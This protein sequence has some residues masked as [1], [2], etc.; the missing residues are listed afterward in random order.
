MFRPEQQIGQYILIRRLGRGGFGE[1]WLAE[2]R[3]KFVTTKVAVKLPLDEQVDH[4]AIRQ[5]AV[6]WEQASGHPNVLPIIEADDYD[7]QVVIVSEYAPDGSLEDLLKKNNGSLPL[8]QAVEMTIG[9]LAGLDFL[10]SRNIIH[11]DLKPANI[12]LQGD[13]PRLADFG[14]SRAMKTTSVSVNIAGTPIYMS[15]E[16]FDRKRNVQTDI[17]AIGVM[18]YQMLTGDFPFPIGNIS[19]IIASIVMHEAEPLPDE[20]PPKLQ[21]IVKK[22]LAKQPAERYQTARDMRGDLADFF[23]SIS[24]QE[25]QETLKFKKKTE[26][27]EVK[28]E[29]LPSDSIAQTQASSTMQSPVF[30]ANT[31]GQKLAETI[32]SNE[33]LE[34]PKFESRNP[35]TNSLYLKILAPFSVLVLLIAGVWLYLSINRQTTTADVIS[36]STKDAPLIPIKTEN[37]KIRYVFV[38]ISDLAKNIIPSDNELKDYYDS[39]PNSEKQAGVLGQEIVLRIASSNSEQQVLEKANQIVVQLKK[40]DNLVS[41]QVFSESAKG[42][43]ENPT[44]ASKGGELPG[45]VRPNPSNPDDPYQRL[46]TMQ[47]GEITEPIKYQDRYFILRRGESVPKTFEEARKEIKIS[48]I[49]QHAYQAAEDIAQKI[50]VDL[51]QT[52]DVQK[53]AQKFAA[54]YGLNIKNMIRETPFIKPGDEL[55]DVGVSKPFDEGIANLENPNDVGDKIL[56]KNGFAIPMLVEKK[57]TK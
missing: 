24:Q 6:L 49:N 3:A 51:K 8:K 14:I 43:S 30:V 37:K 46:I 20:F 48:V 55:P 1:V 53:T 18:L 28:T 45:F 57:L 31:A 12:L 38:S 13:M 16:A 11:R 47:P 56:I 27:T 42:N 5:E 52:K 15:P 9:I 40:E 29:V 4:E 10:H 23:I 21:Q 35:K 19:D 7:G 34:L 17:W 33:I 50:S 26:K 54:L 44:T 36:N 32:Q 22:A 41:E 39:L 25:I 2:R